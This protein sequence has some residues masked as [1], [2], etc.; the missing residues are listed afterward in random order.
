MRKLFV[1]A[2]LAG[3][4]YLGASGAP[5]LSIADGGPL[6]LCPPDGPITK[7]CPDR[8]PGPDCLPAVMPVLLPLV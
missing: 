3:L 7:K 1:A 4:I 2:C 8:C 6:P 5:V